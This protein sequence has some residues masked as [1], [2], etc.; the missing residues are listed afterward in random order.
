MLSYPIAD[1]A[2]AA[3]AMRALLVG[4]LRSPWLGLL[5]V[6]VVAVVMADLL[7]LGVSLTDLTLDPSPLDGL[8]LVSMVLWAAAAATHR[9]RSIRP[10]GSRTGGGPSWRGG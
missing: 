3:V 1:V 8:W 6:G 4:D 10:A 7:N 2:L 9:P 5:L